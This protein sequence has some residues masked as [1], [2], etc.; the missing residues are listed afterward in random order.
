M[1]TPEDAIL[2][3]LSCV[4]PLAAVEEI[5]LLD[6]AGRVLAQDVVS[7][8]DIPPFQK[9]AMDGFAVRSADFG[10]AE[11]GAETPLKV[12]GE[13]RAGGPYEGAIPPGTCVAIY[14]GAVMPE[15]C[16]AV[17][18][19]EKSTSHGAVIALDDTPQPGQN[20]CNRGDDLARGDLALAA[21]RRLS[22]TDLS[23]L[24]SVGRDPVRVFRRP[25]V[26]ILT[27]GDELVP[28]GTALEEGQIWEGNTLHLAGLARR[29]GAE[30]V[31]VGLVPDEPVELE[32]RFG[33]ALENC[34]AVI[35]TG[36][37]SMGEYDLVADVFA[38]LGVR[39]IFHK[40]AIKPGKPIW[41]G[42]RGNRP[43]FALPG[44]P[45]SCLVCHE[46]FVRP[47][48]AKMEGAGPAEL[49]ERRRLGR[50]EGGTPRPNPRQQNLP[51]TITEDAGGVLALEPLAWSSSADIVGL[52]AADGMV[53]IPPGETL[54]PGAIVSF[55]PLR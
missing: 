13:S 51:V 53:I 24:A 18:I 47:A 43:V 38:R 7:G 2:K 32:R 17:V 1:R 52:A 10:T 3:I 50:W 28:P 19:V 40:V 30:I 20:V 54:E 36:G 8:V 5:S 26:A 49:E 39:E 44:N 11:T 29:A 9:S 46:V 27:T 4:E 34:D 45:V 33:A 31:D 48:L 25:R 21:H 37:V 12:L 23:V 22:P 16:D 41:F 15:S 14:T 42:M 35:T 6:A 55:R